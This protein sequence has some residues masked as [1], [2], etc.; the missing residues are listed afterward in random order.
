MTRKADLNAANWMKSNFSSGGD[1]CVEVAFADGSAVIR[2]SKV[3]QG[4]A[5]TVAPESF[6]AFLGEVKGSGSWIS[7]V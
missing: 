3:P 7:N 5:F 1:N 4:P 6:A 2:D